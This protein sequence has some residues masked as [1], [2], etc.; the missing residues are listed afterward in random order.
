MAAQRNEIL[1]ASVAETPSAPI[2]TNFQYL[3]DKDAEPVRG[4]FI[5]HEVPGGVM[6]CSTRFHKG[7]PIRNDKFRDGEIYTIPL[8]VAKHLNKNCWYPEYEFFK[9]ESTQNLQRIGKKKRRCSFQSLEFVDIE[10]LTPNTSSILTVE[11]V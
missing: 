8:G 3:R 5:F 2:K 1:T 7:D 9:D 11:R 4:K 6:E 10:E